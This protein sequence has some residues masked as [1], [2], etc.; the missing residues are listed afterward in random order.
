REDANALVICNAAVEDRKKGEWVNLSEQKSVARSVLVFE[1]GDLQAL[2]PA[3]LDKRNEL[4]LACAQRHELAGE[5]TVERN[6]IKRIFGKGIHNGVCLFARIFSHHQG[7]PCFWPRS[8]STT[9]TP[10][11]SPSCLSRYAEIAASRSGLRI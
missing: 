3:F 2:R 7:R 5:L 10:L 4:L 11:Y 1:L 6:P 8:E 9:I